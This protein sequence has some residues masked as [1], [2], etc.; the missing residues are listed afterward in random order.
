MKHRLLWAS[1]VA[2]A[3]AFATTFTACASDESRSGPDSDAS[4]VPPS[5]DASF[6]VVDEAD[7]AEPSVPCTDD[8]LC[9][10]GP[11]GADMEGGPLDLRTQISVIRARSAS[12]VWIVGANGTVARY[13]GASWRRSDT[14]TQL[15]MKDI[16]LRDEDEIAIVN[17]K[18]ML[19]R[20]PDAAD[21]GVD[22]AVPSADGWMSFGDPLVPSEIMYVAPAV[23]S[24]WMD[25]GAEWAWATT[26][27]G[28]GIW[29]FHVVPETNQI[30]LQH[31]LPTGMCT[32]LGCTKMTSVHGVSPDEL[33]V[34]GYSGEIVRI[35]G[36]QSEVPDYQPFDSQTW[37]ELDAVWVASETEAWAVGGAGVIR[38]YTGH[39]YAW[40]VV[41]DVPTTETLRGVWGSSENDVWAVGDNATVLHYDGKSWSRVAVAGLGLRHP[42]LLAVWTPAPGRVWIAGNGVFLSLGGK[43]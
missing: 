19:R 5:S 28:N 39:P 33:W 35:T 37:A 43:P 8:I 12:D 23:S 16:W 31:G 38:H 21:A 22:G 1:A 2:V 17:P 15:T 4:V 10:F 6:D 20:D 3:G 40:D 32:T 41:T 24:V 29:R 7:A 25:P 30:E 13:D 18:L 11:F 27:G 36:A 9:P 14:G 42:D 34:V 26:L